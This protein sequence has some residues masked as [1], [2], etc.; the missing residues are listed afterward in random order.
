MDL[1]A[2][3]RH[4][5]NMDQTTLAELRALV[6]QFP[7]MQAARLLLVENA[8]RLGE[9][10]YRTEAEK[11][12]VLI[13]DRK[14]LFDLTEGTHLREMDEAEEPF[15][16][17]EDN[18]PTGTDLTATM[19]DRFLFGDTEADFPSSCSPPPDA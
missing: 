6:E 16:D 13:P 18:A 7:C 19:I 10:D 15:D 11:A 4:P 17:E 8:F 9:S 14:V 2:L 5:E 1:T 3:I 12:A